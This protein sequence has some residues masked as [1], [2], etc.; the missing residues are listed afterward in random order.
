M[1][2]ALAAV[3][4]PANRRRAPRWLWIALLVSVAVNLAFVGLAAKS[5][6]HMRNAMIGGPGLA[7]SLAGLMTTLPPER[8]G[9]LRRLITEERA[10]LKS[11]RQ[12]ARRARAETS[13][14]FQA[15]TF[16]TAR[17]D[18]AQ[19]RQIEAELKVRQSMA[20]MVSAAAPKLSLEERRGV[21]T[22]GRQ[23]RA[24]LGKNVLDEDDDAP[25]DAPARK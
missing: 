17:F 4:P 19:A 21:L 18:A 14:A 2:T 12:E 6:W 23:W 11:L 20:R 22:K 7:S 9:E 5:I 13:E 10:A 3:D 1:T 16:D 25:K 24:R 15:D 8:R